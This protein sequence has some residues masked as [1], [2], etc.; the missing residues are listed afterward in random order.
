MLGTGFCLLQSEL[1][2]AKIILIPSVQKKSHKANYFITQVHIDMHTYVLD[3]QNTNKIL[4]AS[5]KWNSNGILNNKDPHNYATIIIVT[6][7]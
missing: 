1:R 4:V 2:L 6:F 3:K 5:F 7:S